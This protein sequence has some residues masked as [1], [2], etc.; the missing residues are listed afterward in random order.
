MKDIIFIV[1]FGIL[2]SACG[3]NVSEKPIQ[4]IAII[5]A[6]C[7]ALNLNKKGW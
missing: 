7:V 1:F 4:T 6:A 3:M 2:L 5:A